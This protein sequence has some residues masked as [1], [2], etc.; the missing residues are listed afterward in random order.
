M[1]IFNTSNGNNL[2]NNSQ[3][4][5]NNFKPKKIKI[6]LTKKIMKNSILNNILE[7]SSQTNTFNVSNNEDKKQI[8]YSNSK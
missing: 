8:K 6:N 3:N 2:S 5:V 7:K 4:F 1:S